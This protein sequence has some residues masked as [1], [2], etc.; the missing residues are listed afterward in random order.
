MGTLS[1]DFLQMGHSIGH[2]TTIHRHGSEMQQGGCEDLRGRYHEPY[3]GRLERRTRD[4]KFEGEHV[5]FRLSPGALHRGKFPRSLRG[6]QLQRPVKREELRIGGSPR[7]GPEP[8]ACQV[9]AYG[10]SER[11]GRRRCCRFPVR[12]RNH[13][14]ARWLII[15]VDRWNDESTGVK[16][17]NFFNL[18]QS[19]CCETHVAERLESNLLDSEELEHD[20]RFPRECTAVH[21]PRGDRLRE[22]GDLE[23]GVQRD[24]G[25]DRVQVF[26][27]DFQCVSGE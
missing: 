23:T 26:V 6:E 7:L 20:P 25:G 12:V 10:L 19:G 14:I 2:A 22:R 11:S 18:F 16:E 3:V 5:Q 4:R 1:T 8:K 21:I 24:G 9:E 15:T 27:R 17:E 13:C